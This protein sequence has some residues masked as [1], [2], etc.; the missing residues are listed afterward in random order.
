VRAATTTPV[1]SPAACLARFAV[2]G[3]LPRYRVGSAPT[4]SFSRPAWCSL[5]LRPARSA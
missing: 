2:D 5:A 3:G 4:L 1:G